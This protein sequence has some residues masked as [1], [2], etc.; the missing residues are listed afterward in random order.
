[1]SSKRNVPSKKELMRVQT[2]S[3]ADYAR[4]APDG[5]HSHESDAYW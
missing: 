5:I 3:E 1:M 4:H 2:S